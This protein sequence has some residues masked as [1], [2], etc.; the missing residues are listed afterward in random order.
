[1]SFC[2]N[3]IPSSEEILSSSQLGFDVTDVEALERIIFTSIDEGDRSRLLQLFE[4][5]PSPT[6]ILQVL[7]T[8]TYPNREGHYKHDPD[9]QIE[10]EELLGP[11]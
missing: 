6:T 4:L 2:G 3:E 10:A 5:H 7:L 9:I 8:T 11:R 1:M